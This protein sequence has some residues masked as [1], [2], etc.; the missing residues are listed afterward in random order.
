M[1]E[2]TA[3]RRIGADTRYDKIVDPSKRG[4]EFSLF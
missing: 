4:K 2:M 1:W 3:R